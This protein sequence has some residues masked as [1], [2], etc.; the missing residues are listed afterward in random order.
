M[1]EVDLDL[2][3]LDPD[4]EDL[5]PPPR[6]RGALDGLEDEEDE[7]SSSSLSR[8]TC[9]P[10]SWNFLNIS[11]LAFSSIASTPMAFLVLSN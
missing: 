8:M 3:P 5:P 4:E 11:C 6:F 1:L 7:L 9:P 10:A 2:L